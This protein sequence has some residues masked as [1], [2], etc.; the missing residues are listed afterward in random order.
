M[1]TAED[2][3]WLEAAKFVENIHSIIGLWRIQAGKHV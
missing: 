3:V 2:G 1:T